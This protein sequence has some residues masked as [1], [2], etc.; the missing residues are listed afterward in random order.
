MNGIYICVN[1]ETL[2]ELDLKKM[3][4]PFG[5]VMCDD[6]NV[7]NFKVARNLFLNSRTVV[8]MGQTTSK[9][10]I[11][12]RTQ[13]WCWIKQ[14]K[15]SMESENGNA[16]TPQNDRSIVT[17]LISVLKLKVWFVFPGDIV[18]EPNMVQI[19]G[20][21]CFS[22]PLSNCGYFVAVLFCLY[23]ISPAT[24]WSGFSNSLNI[25]RLFSQY[26]VNKSYHLYQ[27]SLLLNVLF[28]SLN[29]FDITE[30]IVASSLESA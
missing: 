24:Y 17:A 14:H 12:F 4:C 22:K 19:V 6:S 18:H 28:V 7:F 16:E 23:A 10:S 21:T 3:T 29:K 11:G 5:T 27:Q 15:I 30:T 25:C 20:S 1:I 8:K 26:Q 9:T 2:I 13:E